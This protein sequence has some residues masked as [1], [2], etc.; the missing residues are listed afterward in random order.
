MRV[1]VYFGESRMVK[2]FRYDL[3]DRVCFRGSFVGSGVSGGQ[4]LGVRCLGC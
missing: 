4:F 1:Q 3:E 2:G